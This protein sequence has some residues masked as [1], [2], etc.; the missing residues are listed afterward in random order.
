MFLSNSRRNV[1]RIIVLAFLG[2][3]ILVADQGLEHF[4]RMG[5]AVDNLHT[6][7]GN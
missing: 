5:T 3:C 1:N 7:S 2:F 6:L 4:T